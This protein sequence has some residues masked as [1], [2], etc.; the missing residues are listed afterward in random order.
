VEIRLD[1]YKS[2]NDRYDAALKNGAV[3]SS[4]TQVDRELTQDQLN[5]TATLPK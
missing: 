3:S 2:A 5:I 4:K 1:G